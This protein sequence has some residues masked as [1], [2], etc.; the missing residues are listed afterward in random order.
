MA[1]F[2][3]V[4]LVA[5]LVWIIAVHLWSNYKERRRRAQRKHLNVVK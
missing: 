1:E 4:A 3:T 5:F 2:S